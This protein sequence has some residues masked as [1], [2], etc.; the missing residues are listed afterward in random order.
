MKKHFKPDWFDYFLSAGA[1]TILLIFCYPL[2]SDDISLLPVV[3]A[4]CL[5]AAY[6]LFY[7]LTRSVRKRNKLIKLEF[8]QEWRD[9]LNDKVKFY[10]G[11][12]EK[13]KSKFE[14]EINIF[15]SEKLITGIE[16]DITDTDRLLVASSAIIPVFAFP[17]WNYDDL[18]EV[19]IYPNSFNHEY[20]LEGKGRNISGMVG[21]GVMNGKMILS[22][23]D[24]HYGF[25]YPQSKSNVGIHEFVHLIDDSDGSI[26]GIPGLLMEH[27]Y[28]QPWLEALQREIEKIRKNKSD[29]NAYGGTSKEEFF[30]VISEYFFQRPR[31]F[32]RKHPKLYKMMNKVFRQDPVSRLKKKVALKTK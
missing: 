7:R 19:L 2:Y 13:D 31:L 25:E 30:P 15:I 21:N 3:A 22:K 17:N 4:F 10:R 6:L 28:A 14:R 16:T 12:T 9:I 8:S 1:F 11:L 32:K 29:I 24:L 18:T 26:D 5:I 23:K 20:Q 27:S